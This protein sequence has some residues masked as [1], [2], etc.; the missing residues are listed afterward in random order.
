MNH[1]E[2]KIDWLE[3]Q[4]KG[5]AEW[6]SMLTDMQETQDAVLSSVMRV[7]G[8]CTTE[9]SWYDPPSQP[10]SAWLYED[11]SEKMVRNDKEREN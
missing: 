9:N 1:V 3:A 4:V 7:I 5:I 10:G 2:A 11:V 6:S 8:E